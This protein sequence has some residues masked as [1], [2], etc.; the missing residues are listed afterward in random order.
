MREIF[1]LKEENLR[2]VKKNTQYKSFTL[3]RDTG[4]LKINLN[5]YKYTD[6]GKG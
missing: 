1:Q 3:K 2:L 6:F 5:Q 4:R